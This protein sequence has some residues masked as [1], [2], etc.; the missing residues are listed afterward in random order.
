MDTPANQQAS[1]AAFET[2]LGWIAIAWT[3]DAP[4]RFAIGHPSGQAAILAAGGT[5]TSLDEA[6][7]AIQRLADLFRD[8]ATGKPVDFSDVK[9]DLS[10]LTPLQRKIVACCRKIP[11]GKTLS[12]GELAAKAG[13]PGAARAVGSTMAKNRFPIVVPCH[14]VVAAAG[15]LGGFSAPEGLGLKTRMLQLEG[16]ELGNKVRRR[17]LLS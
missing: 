13:A 4:Q 14:R 7:P 11:R 10:H 17:T 15:K 16:C 12:Y 8:Y 5:A 1:V 9:L 2:A 3:G 6:P